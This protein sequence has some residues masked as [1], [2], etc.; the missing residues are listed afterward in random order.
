MFSEKSRTVDPRNLD[1]QYLENAEIRLQFQPLKL[2]FQIQIIVQ[3]LD[4]Q[5][6]EYI[7]AFNN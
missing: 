4:A 5:F 7:R 2:R 1:I 6:S 3:N